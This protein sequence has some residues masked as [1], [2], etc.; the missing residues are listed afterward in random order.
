MAVLPPGKLPPALLGRLIRRYAVL[1]RRVRLGPGVGEDACAIDMG[2]GRLLVAK[3][4][5]ITFTAEDLG[6]Y[7]LAVNA[8]DIATRG[9]EPRWFLGT[10]LLPEGRTRPR[11]AERHFRQLSAACREMGVSLV[12]GHV[13]VTLGLERPII[14][15]FLLGEVKGKDLLAT[16]DM[17][18]G[19]AIVMTKGAAIEAV[20]VL[21][22]E[23]SREISRRFS[24][25]FLA[26]CRGYI[27]R[28]SVLPEARI[29][30][31]SARAMH[32]PTEGGVA[33]A[34][35]EMA[36]ASGCGLEA[37]EDRIHV[38]AEAR[39]LC[40][41]FKIDPLGAIASGALLIAAAPAGIRRL[42]ARLSLAGIPASVIGKALPR[43]RGVG[44]L[45]PD[46]RRV[47]LKR[48]DQDEL[49]RVL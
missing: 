30:R 16:R 33:T 13:E 19:D 4:D 8:N 7:A 24:P 2:G 20:S 23:K 26:R 39:V 38:P 21:A 35:H 47:P 42:L 43:A 36:E 11:D 17:R 12:G 48:F 29:A 41:Y 5:P 45:K 3:A 18:P 27:G 34:L 1:D 10:L 32:D 49:A 22:R 6:R 46:G 25:A 37:C 44:L 14:A 31:G 40:G 15:G 28:L 9:A